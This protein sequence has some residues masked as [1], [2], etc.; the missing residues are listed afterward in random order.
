MHDDDPADVVARRLRR[1][2]VRRAP[3]RPAG[4]LATVDTIAAV[5]RDQVA[6]YYRRRYQP[7]TMV[8]AAAG[9]AR[10][11]HR[12]PAGAGGVRAAGWT[13]GRRRRGPPRP[14]SRAP[15]GAPARRHARGALGRPSRPTWS[16]AAPGWPATTSAGSRSACSTTRSAAACQ[17][18]AVP[19]DPGEARPG[20]L[21]LL[22]RHPVRRRRPVRRLRRL[23][24]RPRST[25]CSRWSAE[26]LADVAEHGITDEEVAR[27][28]GQLKRRAGARPGGH[29]IADEPD[30]QG[31]AAPTARCSTSTS[32]SP[33]RRGD[34]GRRPGGRRRR[35]APADV[36]GRDRPVQRGRLRR[37]ARLS[38][39]AGAHLAGST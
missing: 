23:R 9:N 36:P 20:L 12:G 29:G 1:G 31:R 28:K 13:R 4:D 19:G 27:G 8:V 26:Q 15:A 17:L 16:S 14:A 3:A 39:P 11:R 33:D 2:A 5:T 22:V 10:P 34:A 30:R 25:R 37:G 6:G 21:G 24:A 18:A 32:C 35:A 38:T 7:E